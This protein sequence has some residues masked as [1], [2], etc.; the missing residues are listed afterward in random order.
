MEQMD[1]IIFVDDG[2]I[3]AVGKYDELYLTCQDFKNLV[4]LQKLDDADD[5]QDLS[6]NK[7]EVS[8]NA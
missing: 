1:K 7:K 4:D 3:A 6:E 5:S 8:E 2:K